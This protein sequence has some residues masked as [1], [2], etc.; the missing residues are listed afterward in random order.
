MLTTAI[1]NLLPSAVAVALSPIPIIAVILMLGTPK[2]RTNGPAFAAGWVLGLAVVSA[3][4]LVVAGGADDP[5]NATSSGIDW[6][7]LLIGLLFL[8][9]AAKQWQQR[10]KAGEEPTMPAWMASV[11]HFT[12]GRSFVL[13]VALSGVNPKNLALTV[14]AMA[15]VAQLGLSSGD[16]VAAVA[17]FVVLA[18]VTVVGSVLFYLVATDRATEALAPVKTFMAEH[19]AVIMMVILLILGAKLIGNGLAGVAS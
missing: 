10:P 2:A 7:T 9:M 17:A 15:S 16:E 11:D 1:G 5:D 12:A 19:N 4:V 18:S 14:A 6:G 8:A 13:G 3:I